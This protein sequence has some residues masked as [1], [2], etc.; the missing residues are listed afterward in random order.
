MSTRPNRTGVLLVNLGTPEAPHTAEVRRYLREFLSDPRVIDMNPLGRFLLLNLIILPFRPARSAEAYEKIWTPE[1][2]PLLVYGRQLAEGVARALPEA[3]VVLA[4]R[5][6]QP[7]L[8]AGL[9]RLRAAGCDHIVVV[10]LYPQYASSTTGST[11]EAVYALAAERWNTPFIQVLPPFF[12]D[13]AFLAAFAAQGRDV[14]AE[15]KPEH[16]LFSFHGL[17]ERQVRKSDEVGD[18]CLVKADCCAVLTH[19]NRNCYRA[20]CVATARGIAERLGLEASAYSVAFQSRLGRVPWIR[21]YTD[22]VLTEL[23]GR[24]VRRV[25]V[26]CPAFVADCLETIEE[27]GLRAVESFKAAGGEQLALVP[28]LNASPA[29]IDALAALIRPRL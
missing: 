27:I 18:H 12:D 3:E 28:S 19:A 17:P 6:G 20:Q 7:S 15:L 11:L 23:A 26:F 1:G 22:D 21:P 24:G 4:M 16:V 2:S 10:P 14:L 29:W 25:A 5:Y 8:A 9:D 13:A